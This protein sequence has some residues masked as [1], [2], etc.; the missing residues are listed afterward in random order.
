[1]DVDAGLCRDVL[2]AIARVAVEEALRPF[3][4][5]RRAEGPRLAIEGEAL[6]EILGRRPR[7]VVADKQVELAVAVVVKKGRRSRKCDRLCVFKEVLRSSRP[8][9]WPA[10]AH[11][12]G[13]VGEAL[14]LVVVE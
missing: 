1:P 14:S 6:T 5:F 9:A 8:A 2:E 12:G 3:K 11:P 10:D 4:R 7:H 13:H